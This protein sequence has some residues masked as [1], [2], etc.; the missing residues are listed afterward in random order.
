MKKTKLWI[1]AIAVIMTSAFLAVRV[2]AQEDTM[3]KNYVLFEGKEAIEGKWYAVDV[4][5][6]G[7][8][9]D[10]RRLRCGKRIDEIIHYA[11]PAFHPDIGVY[12]HGDRVCWYESGFENETDVWAYDVATGKLFGGYLGEND[13]ADDFD[14]G[15]AVSGGW[16]GKGKTNLYIVDFYYNFNP[17]MAKASTLVC[18]QFHKSKALVCPTGGE[19]WVEAFSGARIQMNPVD[20]PWYTFYNLPGRS[21]ET[22]SC[23]I[24]IHE[25]AGNGIALYEV[26]STIQHWHAP[27][28]QEF[29]APEKLIRTDPPKTV[30]YGYIGLGCD[31]FV[32]P[33]FIKAKAFEGDKAKVR[34]GNKW[35]S[36]T[37]EEIASY[38]PF[39]QSWKIE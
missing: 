5:D 35:L 27:A 25:P 31:Y 20:R 11:D 2:Q 21:W 4:R 32:Q 34:I 22:T 1:T 13:M 18:Y 7:K 17:G 9:K 38:D 14:R 28:N 29:G 33:M 39:I 19:N 36:L 8:I 23:E 24:L 10:G 3:K 15:F 16:Y 37:A 26:I 12:D 6:D 30:A